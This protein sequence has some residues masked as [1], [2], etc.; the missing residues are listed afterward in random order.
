MIEV[1]IRLDMEKEVLGIRS[2]LRFCL[3]KKPRDHTR[4]YRDYIESM[5]KY[6][7]AKI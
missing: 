6:L 3:F 2:K 5:F 1:L 7:F 4:D